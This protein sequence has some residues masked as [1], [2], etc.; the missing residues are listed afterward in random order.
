MKFHMMF[1]KRKADLSLISKECRVF[2]GY[3]TVVND[4]RSNAYFFSKEIGIKLFCEQRNGATVTGYAIREGLRRA[5][6][7]VA[8]VDVMIYLLEKEIPLH[9]FKGLCLC[10]WATQ[11][12]EASIERSLYVPCLEYKDEGGRWDKTMT[13][14]N[15]NFNQGHAHV[16]LDV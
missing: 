6:V 3:R 14:L 2:P 1:E 13:P 12:T 5:G 4:C 10:F 16:I 7:F 15:D 9:G 11:Y 8:G